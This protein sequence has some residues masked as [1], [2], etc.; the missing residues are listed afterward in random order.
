M[1]QGRM[2]PELPPR[3]DRRLAIKWMLA[4]GASALLADPLLRAQ[5]AAGT[6][7]NEVPGGYGKDTDL[8]KEHKPGEFWPLTFTDAVRRDVAAL[9]DL[10]IPADDRSPSA[11]ALGVPYFIDEWVSAPYPAQQ[12]DRAIVLPGLAWVDARSRERFG[13]A[14]ADATAEGRL[15]LC[16]EMAADAVAGSPLEA[17]SR[18]FRRFRDLTAAGFFS[19]PAGMKDLGYVGNVP[20]PRFE[21]PP[22]ELVERLGLSDEVKW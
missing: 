17:P 8:V 9:C 12:K 3:M 2:N 4:A 18:F 16:E 19:T 21:G 1:N 11:S 20:L 5:S 10:V 15:S 14:F 7:L 6:P 13:R 22:S